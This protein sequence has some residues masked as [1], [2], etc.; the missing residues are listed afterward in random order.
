MSYDEVIDGSQGPAVA[1]FNATDPE[2]SSIL[3]D[4]KG[5]DAA[6]FTISNSGA[7]RFV[8]PP[9]YEDPQDRAAMVDQGDDN[10]AD[11]PADFILTTPGSD[12][13]MRTY[14]VVVRAIENRSNRTPASERT[15]PAQTVERHVRVTV[16]NGGRTR[17]AHPVMDSA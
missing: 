10:A 12:A 6:S 2:G 3:W 15:W 16:Q 1:T 4:L 9:D 7:L 14:D 13:G 5:T 8:D 11:D 17:R